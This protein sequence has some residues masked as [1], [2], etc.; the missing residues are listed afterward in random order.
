MSLRV[1]LRRFETH[2]SAFRRETGGETRGVIFF[3]AQSVV[4][5]RGLVD[6]TK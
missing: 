3:S 4:S 6:E 2:F 1:A 5:G